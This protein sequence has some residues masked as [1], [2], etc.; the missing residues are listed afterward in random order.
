MSTSTQVPFPS[1]SLLSH[2]TRLFSSFSWRSRL[3]QEQ[4]L[5]GDG[6]SI[7]N[8]R[9]YNRKESRRHL[10]DRQRWFVLSALCLLFFDVSFSTSSLCLSSASI[11]AKVTRDHLLQKWQWKGVGQIDNNYGSGY[12][13]DEACVNWSVP[14]TCLFILSLS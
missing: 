10:Q 9:F 4:T 6:E 2:S 8:G 3:L 12:P 13:G 14:S 1:P 7:F 5:I 11:I